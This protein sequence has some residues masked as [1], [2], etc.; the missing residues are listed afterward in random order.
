MWL[1][2]TDNI[3]Y[4]IM[5]NICRTEIKK[6]GFVM[7]LHTYPG[8]IRKNVVPLHFSINAPDPEQRKVINSFGKPL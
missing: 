1:G 7:P 6:E 8:L 3:K 2:V 5:T 4:N